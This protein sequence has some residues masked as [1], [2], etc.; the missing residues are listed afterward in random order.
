MEDICRRWSQPRP[1]LSPSQFS[2]GT[3]EEFQ[4]KNRAVSSEHQVMMD[5]IP[6]IRANTG[7][8]FHKAGN[9]PFNNLV[10]F[11]PGITDAKVDGYDGARPIEIELAVRRD[12]HGYII[13][14]TRTDLP[15]VP[16]HLTEVKGPAGRA[17]VLR[18]QAMY[19]GAVGARGM[20]E[21]QPT[22][23][24][25]KT[26]R[27]NTLTT[28][29]QETTKYSISAWMDQNQPVGW[30]STLHDDSKKCSQ[31]L[32]GNDDYTLESSIKL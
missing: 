3:F 32:Q 6:T 21:L 24:H 10:E 18:R 14:S 17:D 1:S 20:F 30:S 12:L 9:T 5:V 7:T 31:K 16:N 8:R 26:Q 15:A 13:P 19:A 11:A 27:K 4:D 23:Q 29:R 22:N 2:E 28:M 25:Q